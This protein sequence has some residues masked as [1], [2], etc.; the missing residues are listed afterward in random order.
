MPSATKTPDEPTAATLEL[1]A[2]GYPISEEAA[3]HWF[4]DRYWR[5]PT[6]QEIGAIIGEMA[7]REATPP[8][9][10]PNASAGGW[11]VGP[12]AAPATRR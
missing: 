2:T 11:V 7:Q 3:E 5:E 12:S 10:G 1:P 4:R 6:E 8:H 9:D